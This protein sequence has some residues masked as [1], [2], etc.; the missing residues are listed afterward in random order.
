MKRILLLAVAALMFVGCN[1]AFEDEGNARF[2]QNTLPTLTAAF[3]EDATRTYVENNKYL[4][5]HEGDLISVFYGT[6]LNSQYKFIGN[7]GANSG[8]FEPIKSDNLS[9]GNALDR[10]YAVY[11]Y[12]AEATISDLGVISYSM[13]A[14][15]T[16]AEESFGRGANVMVAATESVD[17]KF[18]SFKNVGG[19]LKIK[20]YGEGSVQS[21]VVKGNNDEKI[22]GRA[23]VAVD[24]NGVPQYTLTDAAITLDCGEGVEL[25][26]DAENPTEFWVVV[27]PTTFESGITITVTDTEGG[28]FEKSTDKQIVIER[29]IIQ[30]MSAIEAE[31][32]VYDPTKPA[33]NE[34]WYTS[35]TGNV[36]NPFDSEVFGAEIVSNTYE[37]GTGVIKFNGTVTSIGL[38]A[39]SNVTALTSIIIPNGVKTIGERAFYG[40]ANLNSVAIG[41]GVTEIG[42]YAFSGCSKLPNITIPDSVITIGAYAFSQCYQLTNVIIGDGVTEIG[43]NVFYNCSTLT[44]ITIGDSLSKIGVKAFYECKKLNEILGDNILEDD[45]CIINNGVLLHCF[46][47][48]VSEYIIPDGVTLAAY[49]FKD[50]DELTS[51]TIPDSVTTIGES[52]FEGCG[53]LSSVTIGNGLKEIGDKAFYWC[54]KLANINLP[55]S[56]ITIG[57]AAFS[58]CSNLTSINLPESVETI[59]A[60]AFSS[61]GLKSISIPNNITVI[62]ANTFNGCSSL[63]SVDLGDAVVEIG[64]RV[65]YGCSNLNSVTIPDCVSEIGSY[66]FYQCNK[67]EDIKLPNSLTSVKDQCFAFCVDAFGETL[68]IPDNVETIGWGSFYGVQAPH[69]LVLGKGLRKIGRYAFDTCCKIESLTIPGNVKEIEE[70]AFNNCYLIKEL[71]LEEGVESI[72]NCAF[73]RLQQLKSVEI[74]ASVNLIGEKAFYNCTS[75]ASVYCKSETPP[76]VSFTSTWNAFSKNADGRKIYVPESNNYDVVYAYK[77]AS[78]WCDY[79]DAITTVSGDAPIYESTD[80]SNDGTVVT[81]QTAKEGNGIDVVLMGDGYSDRLVA[82]GTYECDMQKTVNFL[83]DKEPF[84]SY[85]DLFNVY[86]VTA[87]SKHE[88]F[89]SGNETVF[90]CAFGDGTSISGDINLML[91][92]AKKAISEDRVN[93]AT[94][95]TVMNAHKISGISTLM[96]PR[97]KSTDYGSGTGISIVAQGDNDDAFA[98]LVW[99]EAGGHSFAKLGDEYAYSK[100]G[101][102]TDSALTVIAN[103]SSYGWLKNL[104]TT[105]DTNEVKWKHFINDERYVDEIGV[106]EG[107]YTY[108]YGVWRPTKNSIMNSGSGEFNA[109]SREAIY[110]RIHKLAYGDSWN[111]SYEDF[112]EYDAINRNIVTSQTKAL[113][114]VKTS[115]SPVVMTID[116]IR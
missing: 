94:I 107:G 92:Y 82:N 26:A 10:I 4:R 2:E 15:Q 79:A 95:I 55:N 91:D 114:Y 70:Y 108:Y 115:T 8:E 43:G 90:G 38:K 97:D 83:F 30:P 110:Y 77:L 65:F 102:V 18:L 34:I 33:K 74:P 27:P 45:S 12:D 25:S 37:N 99:H 22:A 7:T 87:V 16:Y 106:F 73:Y 63:T 50:C 69:T 64:D 20:L 93:E 21:I 11:P 36:I 53:K 116:S 71:I 58:L 109:P 5:W 112:V 39:F 103:Q 14:T 28:V 40:C 104:D 61:S 56:L 3:D 62:E 23:T 31:F 17:D 84:R 66:A 32:E 100:N 86:Y 42:D 88:G 51:I 49:A 101:T 54:S 85:R 60:S 105:K 76:A 113:Q 41:N 111:Y 81:L 67:L 6:T 78:G 59:K 48:D 80:F 9:T 35:Y 1:N 57:E 47:Y 24:E 46:K 75:L 29:N 19:Y 68:I 52:T 13:P 89:A 72:G 44:S 98:E 96:I